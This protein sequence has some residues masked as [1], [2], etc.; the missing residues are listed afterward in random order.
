MVSMARDP[1]RN[2]IWGTQILRFYLATKHLY[3]DLV[4]IRIFD[5]LAAVFIDALIRSNIF[6]KHG[7]FSTEHPI[8][9]KMLFSF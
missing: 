6:T 1:T 3:Y 5:D 2:R 8:P 7:S 4:Q 9:A